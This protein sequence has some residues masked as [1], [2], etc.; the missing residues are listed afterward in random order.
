MYSSGSL[1]PVN[2]GM[3]NLSLPYIALHFVGVEGDDDALDM[4]DYQPHVAL[5]MED[6]HCLHALDELDGVGEL[7]EDLRELEEELDDA[8][9]R[10]IFVLEF[11]R[12][13]L[14]LYC[15]YRG[16]GW[17]WLDLNLEGHVAPQELVLHIVVVEDIEPRLRAHLDVVALALPLHVGILVAVLVLARKPLGFDVVGALGS[18]CRVE[19]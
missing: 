1:L 9:E 14:P 19:D 2:L 17:Q 5:G 6:F 16:C 13:V 10:E 15:A 4:E 3:V 7:V 11:L 8:R 18:R 12:D